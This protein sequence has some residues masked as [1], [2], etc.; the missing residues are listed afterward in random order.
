MVRRY[1]FAGGWKVVTHSRKL[2]LDFTTAFKSKCCS[3][4]HR[5]IVVST[6]KLY[7][8]CMELGESWEDVYYDNLK[9]THDFAI[10]LNTKFGSFWCR[11]A[12]ILMSNYAPLPI[13]PPFS[14]YG[15]P[16][17]SKMVLVE[18]SI[19]HSYSTSMHTITHILLRLATMHNAADDRHTTDGA[20]KQ[21][22][23][24]IASA[25]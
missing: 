23:F 20:I 11:S 3:I 14:G 8:R 18:M 1:G 10:P 25:A 21:T 16:R 5:L 9:P 13:H 24:A 4:C 12:E 2:T 19:P 7:P 17:G 22:A 15:G 6:R